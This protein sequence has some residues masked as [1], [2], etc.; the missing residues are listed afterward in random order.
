MWILS[1]LADPIFDFIWNVR[2]DP[3]PHP[4]KL[5][6]LHTQPPTPPTP[7]IPYPSTTVCKRNEIHTACSENLIINFEFFYYYYFIEYFIF[8][9]KRRIYLHIIKLFFYEYFQE[10][11]ILFDWLWIYQKLTLIKISNKESRG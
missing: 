2:F 11:D 8:Y 3:L 10:P 6:P 5:H 4:N 7:P 1:C 9:R